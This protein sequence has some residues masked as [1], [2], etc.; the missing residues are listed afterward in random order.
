MSRFTGSSPPVKHETI[1][2][3]LNENINRA[4]LFFTTS[5]ASRSAPSFSRYSAILPPFCSHTFVQALSDMGVETVFVPLGEADG[6][7]VIMAEQRGGYV[8]GQDS[9][10]VILVGE[11]GKGKGYI[12]FE[13]ITWYIDEAEEEEAPEKAED[14]WEPVANRRNYHGNKR[15]SPLLPPTDARNP[16]LSLVVYP[17]AALRQRL[18]L[19]A[20]VLP[21]FAA[22]VG[23]DYTPP[24]A[25]AHFFEPGLQLGQRIEKVARVMREQL[26]SPNAS[27]SGTAGDHAADLVS[28]VIKKLLYREFQSD[29]E[30]H[31]MADAIVEATLQYT[32]PSLNQCCPRFPFCG[33]L[34]TGCRAESGIPE[35]AQWYSDAHSRGEL[36]AVRHA[37]LFPN[38]VIPYQAMEDPGKASIK[39]QGLTKVRQVAWEIAD[40]ALGLRFP[41]AVDEDEVQGQI[42]ERSDVTLVGESQKAAEMTTEEEDKDE[43]PATPSRTLIEYV[44]S[45][46][47]VIAREVVLAERPPHDDLST[48]QLR[49][50][51]PLDDRLRLFVQTMGSDLPSIHALPIH[52]QPLV[53]IIR[54]C[55]TDTRELWRRTEVEGVLRACIGTY[56]AWQRENNGDCPTKKETL[57][58]YPFLT[59]RRAQIVAYL[60]AVMTDAHV[61]AESLLLSN[62]PSCKDSRAE[63]DITHLRTYVFFSGSALHLFLA[64]EEPGG[65]KWTPADQEA[66]DQCLAAVVEGLE[67]RILGWKDGDR[68]YSRQELKH[69][70]ETEAAKLGPDGK[71]KGRAETEGNWRDVKSKQLSGRFDLLN[72]MTTS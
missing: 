10:F 17:P 50:L 69:Y 67:D 68:I 28:R 33:N 54:F 37:F 16:I 72:G 20:S 35:A 7:C 52:F 21:L 51:L 42:D 18:R 45:S 53:A 38:A 63:I 1:V 11:G 55:L 6:V 23:N 3:R 8:L 5:P 25:G 70:D 43:T 2:G 65:W 60:K 44:R 34:D 29:G 27:K 40:E 36:R 41:P 48:T 58:E 31:A 57:L 15:Q 30:R 64:G 9:D 46:N 59:N 66:Y 24:S 56:A 62:H 61:L 12:P 39:L 32:L 4:Q 26:F 47:R 13:M 14:E 22:L 49:C 71:R 19:P